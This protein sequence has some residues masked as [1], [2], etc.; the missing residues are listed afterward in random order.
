M[1]DGMGQTTYIRTNNDQV[2]LAS[3]VSAKSAHLSGYVSRVVNWSAVGRAFFLLW[4]AMYLP[5]ES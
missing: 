1:E 4:A 2:F 5:V 3:P